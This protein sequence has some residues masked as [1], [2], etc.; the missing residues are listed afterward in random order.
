VFA[1]G[2]QSLSR[3]LLEAHHGGAYLDGWGDKL[4]M[5]AWDK[6]FAVTGIDAASYLGPRKTEQTLPWD[7]M[8]MG[9]EKGFLL[10]ERMRAHGEKSTSDCRDG[11][12]NR[13]GVCAE[14]LSNIIQQKPEPIHLFHEWSAHGSYSYVI[15]ISKEEGLRFLSPRE[16]QEMLRR[17][18]RRAGLDAI[19]S[20]GFSPIMKLSTTPPTSYGIAS[21]CEY[22]S[23]ELKRPVNPR[24]ISTRLNATLPAG[25][26]I[27]SCSEGKL[28]QVRACIYRTLKPFTLSLT[29]D[30]CVVKEGK[31]LAVADYLEY[32]DPTTLRLAFNQG[33]T[34]SPV[35]LLETYSPDKLRMED[36]IKTET[37]FVEDAPMGKAPEGNDIF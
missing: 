15:G 3:L 9:I 28:K 34:I 29:P 2:D 25:S 31:T 14:G 32:S 18:I 11:E 33:R 21:K 30:A 1:R 36:I 17:A 19:Y 12:C 8:D 26:S 20:Q 22:V 16:F 7:F 27:V 6:A 5:Q 4:N 10:A 13:C 35:L 24:E 23:I 37:L